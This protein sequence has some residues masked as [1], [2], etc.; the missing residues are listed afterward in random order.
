MSRRG[1]LGLLVGVLILLA[2][3]GGLGY[4]IYSTTPKVSFISS[5]TTAPEMAVV[6]NPGDDIQAAVDTHPEYTYFI[7]KPG[8]YRLQYIVPKDGMV[9]DGR[10]GAILNGATLI[11]QFERDG[12]YWVIPDQTAEG[13]R[14]GTC[15]IEGDETCTYPEILY[16]DD[17]PLLHAASL[18]E[19]KPGLFYFDYDNDRIYLVDNPTG[20]KV[21]LSTAP[22][23]FE[24][25]AYKVGIRN[26]TIE[27]YANRPQIGAIYGPESSGWVV[28]NNTVQLN[29]GAGI[30]VGERMQVLNN[31]VLRNGQIGISGIGT[32]VLVQGNEIAYNNFAKFSPGWEAGATKFVSTEHLV[33]RG[34]YVHDNDGHGIWMDI[35]NINTL[36]EDNLIVNNARMGIFNEISYSIII[37]NNTVMLN[38]KNYMEWAYGA[39]IQISSSRDAEIYNN[40]VVVSDQGGHGI[41]ILEQERGEGTYG[42]RISINN[43]VHDNLVAYLGNSGESGVAGVPPDGTPGR[44]PNNNR[45]DRNTYYALD[46]NWKHWGW[47][48]STRTWDDFRA[49]GQEANGVFR[50]S[51]PSEIASVPVWAASQAASPPL[52]LLLASVFGLVLGIGIFALALAGRK[53]AEALTPRAVEVVDETSESADASA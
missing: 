29:H 31:H 35:D 37:R 33:V 43:F 51:M 49:Q 44:P 11:T 17:I 42:P 40:R 41:Y 21:E 6:L 46:Q 39:Q 30:V 10:G 48:D 20:R 12:E 1:W 5:N 16:I 38:S 50:T 14:A 13:L 52:W 19:V 53:P 26:M 18:D 36:V 34:N 32:D 47:P 8:I 7:L 25:T 28:E 27:K 45:F 2:G 3:G 22:L 9:F 23:A 4:Y 24:G 15:D